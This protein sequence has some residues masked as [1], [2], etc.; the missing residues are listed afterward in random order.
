MGLSFFGKCHTNSNAA[1]P[2]PD[3]SRYKVLSC[4]YFD[5][6]TLL[7]VEYLDCTNFEGKKAIVY[8]GK[9]SP[10]GALDPHFSEMGNSPIARFKPD[11][12]GVRLARLFCKSL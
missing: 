2:N 3:P 8:K 5:N 10:T 6:A 7:I 11:F 4:E 12:E 9:F 1:A